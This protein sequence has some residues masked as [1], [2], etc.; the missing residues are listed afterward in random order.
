MNETQIYKQLHIKDTKE[1][2]SILA[3]N[4]ALAQLKFQ[5]E[6]QYF[7]LFSKSNLNNIDTL[8][9]QTKNAGGLKSIK[10]G[11][12]KV[13]GWYAILNKNNPFT[14]NNFIYKVHTQPTLINTSIYYKMKERK[15]HLLST[16]HLDRGHLLAKRFIDEKLISIN[17]IGKNENHTLLNNRTKFSELGNLDNIFLQFK[18]ANENDVNLHGQAYFEQLI[19]TKFANCKLLNQIFY[20]V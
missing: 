4:N 19:S 1:L 20:K 15:L 7:D 11:S 3:N 13:I 6:Y 16:Y 17:A 18:Q 2:E 12:N 10:L 5:V 14:I 8:L 9:N